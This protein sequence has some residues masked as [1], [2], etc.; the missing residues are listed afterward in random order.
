[1][2]PARRL[3]MENK[4]GRRPW[5]IWQVSSLITKRGADLTKHWFSKVGLNLEIWQ[6]LWR[7]VTRTTTWHCKTT[8]TP[9]ETPNGSSSASPIPRV[10]MLCVSAYWIFASRTRFIM[11][12]WKSSC[13]QKN[14]QQPK[15][16]G[17]TEE[18][19]KF[20]IIKMG[21]ERIITS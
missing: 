15:T 18:G 3:L 8:S 11:R 5:W 12:A 10:S 9:A 16:S 13:I 7:W 14:M 4:L 20:H 17:G 2:L 19:L 21:S 1:M 6:R